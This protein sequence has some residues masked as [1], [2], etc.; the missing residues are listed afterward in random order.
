MAATISTDATALTLGGDDAGL[1]QISGDQIV[2]TAAL[3]GRTELSFTVTGT[4]S[5]YTAR[6]RTASVS[7]A[8]SDQGQT[9]TAA[10]IISEEDYDIDTGAMSFSITEGGTL[11]WAIY[12]GEDGQ[13]TLNSDG[14][15]SGPVIETGSV[16]VPA[17]DGSVTLT[18]DTDLGN[19][20]AYGVIDA[21][22]NVSNIIRENVLIGDDPLAPRFVG[23]GQSVWGIGNLTAEW[24]AGHQAGDL[25]VGVL[26]TRGADAASPAP[27][28]WTKQGRYAQGAATGDAVVEVFHRTAAGAAEAG[29]RLPD[30]WNTGLLTMAVYRPAGSASL[31]LRHLGN[32]TE[33]ANTVK[34]TGTVLTI[35]TANTAAAARGR[36]LAVIGE[37]TDNAVRQISQLSNKQIQAWRERSVFGTDQNAGGWLS[38]ADGV[39]ENGP[40]ATGAINATYPVDTSWVSALFEIVEQ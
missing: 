4:R 3:T 26:L 27:A 5:G 25:A 39:F 11:R 28:G 29:L 12:W 23:M 13:P 2:T 1:V 31:V 10:P 17:G 38:L 33:A 19:R 22:G 7:V 37:R 34:G 30:S 14:S 16:A 24:P 35:P 20:I 6:A 32:R 18:F 9:D 40:T 8:A 36:I 15:W 21:A